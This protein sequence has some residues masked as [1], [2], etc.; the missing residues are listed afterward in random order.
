MG[1]FVFVKPHAVTP[2]AIALV[3]EKLAAAGITIKSTGSLSAETID[4]EMLIDTHY[5]AIASKAVKLSPSE[6]NVQPKA[7]DAFKKAFG[8]TWESA[9]S[10]GLVYNAKDACTK[11]NIDSVALDAKWSTLNK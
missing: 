11:L 10:Q 4:K 7:K 2:A 3:K 6:L 8:M 1:A 9:L 5:G